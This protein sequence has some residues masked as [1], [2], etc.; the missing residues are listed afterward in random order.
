MNNPPRTAPELEPMPSFDAFDALPE[1]EET[2]ILPGSTT[3]ATLEYAHLLHGVLEISRA[4]ERI[5]PYIKETPLQPSP[6]LSSITGNNVY[7][8]REDHQAIHSFKIRGALNKLLQLT[9]E[10]RAKGVM[11]ASAGNHA[12]GVAKGAKL[13]GIEARVV[14]P[15]TTPDV[16]V[17]AVK[18]LGAEVVPFGDNF[19]DAYEHAMRLLE[20]TEQTFIHPFDDMDVIHG[21]G[22]IGLEVLKQ[23]PDVDIVFIPGGG[24]GLAAGM[25]KAIKALKPSTKVVVVEPEGSNA[26]QRAVQAGKPVK[27]PEPPDIFADGVA[28]SQVGE[29][30]FTEIRRY[31]DDIITV[32][33]DEICVAISDFWQET[34]DTLEGAGA[35][36]EAGLKK[37]VQEMGIKDQ[38]LVAVTSGSN[39]SAPKLRKALE[40]AEIVAAREAFFS[41]RL[42]EEAGS[43]RQFCK[44]IVDGH[45]ITEFHYRRSNAVDAHILIAFAMK[46]D[47]DKENFL[48]KMHMQGYDSDD[49]TDDDFVKD[50][51]RHL[52]GGRGDSSLEEELYVIDLPERSGALS[53]F[54]DTLEDRWNIS[55]FHYRSFGGETSRVLIGFETNDSQALQSTFDQGGYGHQRVVSGA[56]K[57]FL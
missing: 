45:N 43:L 30:T 34:G 46:D 54:L 12:Q 6:R 24:G 27:M 57:L 14:M 40:R 18:S 7:F 3:T 47:H 16:K 50:H 25:A 42:P 56:V 52:G 29:L 55:L 23:N 39:I 22:T 37:Y 51:L 44:S 13:L 1:H 33:E 53:E 19:G 2:I 38:N 26:I 35:L 9:D 48:S 49:F 36:A 20:D 17:E 41:V 21:Q 11:A 4:A 8:K 31:V 28:V 5:Q 10:E 32:G 15:E